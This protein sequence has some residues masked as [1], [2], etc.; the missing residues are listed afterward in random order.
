MKYRVLIGILLCS[1]IAAGCG[2]PRAQASPPPAAT[3][4]AFSIPVVELSGTGR[5]IGTEYGRQLSDPIHL[6]F[7]KY[8]KP[9]FRN[10]LQRAV[11]LTA[12]GAFE[13]H[14]LP[15]HRAEVQ[16]LAQATHLDEREVMLA[17]CF[18][19]LLPG[20]AA[21]STIALPAEAS[22]DGVARFGRNLDFPSLGVADKQSVVFIY[23]PA[24]GYQFAAIGWPGL[25]GVLSGMNEHGLSLANMEVKR[26]RRLPA[27]MPYTLL[28][29]L[30]LE[31]CKT[32]DEAIELLQNT[33]RQTANNL[34]L[35]DAGGDRAVVEITPEAIHVRRAP[36]TAALISTNHQRGQD[37]D[38]AGRCWRFDRLHES[39]MRQFG[40]IDEPAMQNLLA[41]VS[42]GKLTL[43]SMVFE[44]ANRVIYLAT[45][46]N[47]PSHLYQ[48][49]DL[50]GYF[51]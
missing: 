24:G 22:P 11:A 40:Q 25:V 9:Y 28:Y 27:A 20:M 7:E 15:E 5:Q 32:V 33:P 26:S 29:R 13:G 47:A 21:C 46:A 38:S 14:L 18:L 48:R 36:A 50:K 12:A 3:Q 44:P 10:D 35:M 34:M 6:L 42:Q 31:R 8:L 43:Q 30:V 45:G 51:H 1:L 16:A 19:D 41:R 4:A 2:K 17:Q 39:A 37:L 49:L 23:R